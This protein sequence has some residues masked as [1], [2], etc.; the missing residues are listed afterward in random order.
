M[1]KVVPYVLYVHY[2]SYI[3]DLELPRGIR[4]VHEG[5]MCVC[6]GLIGVTC[7]WMFKRRLSGEA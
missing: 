1:G 3:D 4:K 5:R 2:A 7:G 6:D